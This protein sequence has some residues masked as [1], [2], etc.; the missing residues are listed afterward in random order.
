MIPTTRRGFLKTTGAAVA[1][2]G[3]MAFL[4]SLPR[5][6]ADDAELDP[7]LVRLNSDI[8]PL[9]RTLEDTPREKLLETIA[10]RIRKGLSYRELL[11]ALLLAGVRNIQP[12][13][14]VGFKFHAVLVINS[15][16][17]ASLN[18][19][20][21]ERWLPIFWALD[22]F[23]D[24]QSATIKESGWRMSPVDE[25]KV[26]T[27]HLAQKAFIDAMENWGEAAADAAVAGL[28]RSAASHQAFELL[29]RYG[30]RDFRDIGHKA[31]YVANSF[32]TLQCIG[33]QYA[34][35]VLRSLTYA[36]MKNEGKNPAKNDLAPDRPWRRNETAIKD[37]RSDWLAGKID[38]GA[39][40]ELLAT[41]RGGSDED[42]TRLAIQMLNRGIA[43]QSI[44]DATM[45]SAAELLMRQSGIVSLHSMTMSN[46]LRYAYDSVVDERLRLQ[47]LLQNVAVVPL[48]RGAAAGRGKLSDANIDTLDE[49]PI[50]SE[51]APIAEIFQDVSRDRLQAARKTLAYLKVHPQPKEL[52]DAAR[53]TTFMKGTDAHDYKFSS[54][55]F[56]DYG[57]LSPAW[58]DRYLAASMFYLRGSGAK[59]NELVKRTRAALNA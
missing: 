42:A 38:D 26:P 55:V 7:K 32:R 30:A 21:A 59:D 1:G 5:V 29:A 45:N 41:L 25:S 50:Q 3:G 49:V 44:W 28:A 34:E 8:A 4:S 33:W 52:I 23:K 31:I 14:N 56:E 57:H 39:A 10:E 51:D 40:R 17:L 11:A 22:H 20:D 13:P 15:A 43:P 2:A 24:S 47:L 53:V 36:L 27:A 58:R 18:S 35:P 9:V 12:R 54:A 46:A 16:H 6:S 37:V 48:F 19:P